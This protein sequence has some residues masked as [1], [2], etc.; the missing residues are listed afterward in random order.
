MRIALLTDTFA[1]RTRFGL[2]RYAHEIHGGLSRYGIDAVP[3]SAVSDFGETPPDW[4]VGSGFRK[5]P[6]S[7]RTLATVWAAGSPQPRLERWVDDIDLVHSLD[8]DYPVATAKPWVV[9]YHDLGVL[10]H[11]DYFGK[12]RPWL[13]RAHIAAAVRRADAIVCVSRATAD[14]FL[15]EGGKAAEGRVRVIEEGVGAEFF[16]RPSAEGM[17]ALPQ[18]LDGQPFFLFTGSISPRKNLARVIAAF[19]R[20]AEKVPHRLVLTGAPGWDAAEEMKALAASGVGDRVVELG[21]VSDEVLKALYAAASGFLYPSLYEG[22]GLPILE[23][24]AAGCPVVTSN[25]APMTEVGGDAALYV[26]PHRSDEIAAAMLTLAQDAERRQRCRSD[27]VVQAR[28]FG[29]EG[30]VRRTVDLYRD[31]IWGVAR[32]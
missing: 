27:G 15:A 2:S 32:G 5:L 12:A 6:W 29:W 10:T 30:C 24:M 22:F 17:A 25:M 16:A 13:L 8:V 4:L 11:P 26:D 31:I 3:V 20:I 18:G 7:R 21:Y 23:A 19:A 9:T 28:R 14:E 1:R